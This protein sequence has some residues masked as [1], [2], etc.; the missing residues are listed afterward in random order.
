M[1]GDGMAGEA[2]LRRVGACQVK[3]W[4]NAA[5]ARLGQA[6]GEARSG[7]HPVFASPALRWPEPDP[8]RV[9]FLF[10]RQGLDHPLK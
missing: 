8:H 2:S 9:L 4:G 3:V 5:Q 1:F 6:K 7:F 10:Y